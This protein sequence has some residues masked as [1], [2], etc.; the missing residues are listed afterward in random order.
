MRCYFPLDPIN[1]LI[2]C[3][4]NL[5]AVIDVLGD[6]ENFMLLVIADVVPSY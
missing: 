5:L 2:E 6:Y 3:A 4:V 1:R